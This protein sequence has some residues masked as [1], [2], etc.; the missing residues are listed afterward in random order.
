MNIFWV[1]LFNKLWDLQLQDENVSFK[2]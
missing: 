1:G 2:T